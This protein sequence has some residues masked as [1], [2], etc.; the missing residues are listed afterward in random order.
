MLLDTAASIEGAS[1]SSLSKALSLLVVVAE[2]SQKGVS[3]SSAAARTGL[4]VQPGK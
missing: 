2:R 3:L 4:H 1:R